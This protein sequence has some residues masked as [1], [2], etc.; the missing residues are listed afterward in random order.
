MAHYVDV[1]KSSLRILVLNRREAAHLCVDLQNHL[2]FAG[3]AAPEF[4]INQEGH[5]WH[6]L[7]I[8]VQSENVPPVLEGPL[9]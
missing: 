9:G 3:K 2:L 5:P 4:E 6:K 8:M 1:E 7:V